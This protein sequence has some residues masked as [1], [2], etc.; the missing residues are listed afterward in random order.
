MSLDYSSSLEFDLFSDLENQSEEE[1]TE[2]IREPTMEEYMTITRINY[3]SGNEKGRIELKG[4]FLI[5]LRDNA[6]SG[7]NAASKRKIETNEVNIKVDWDPT[8]IEFESWLASKFR[9]HK[10][11]DRYTKNALWDYWRRGDDEE[12]ITDNGLSNPR[13]DNLIEEN[14]IAQIFR[15]DTDIFRLFICDGNSIRYEDYEWYDTIDDG[16]LKEEALINKWI[17]EES[18]KV[19]EESSDDKWDHDSPV[20]E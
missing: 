16:E 1:V 7:I 12:V 17:L 6:F 9:N 15:I 10:T 3:E 19:M 11:M 14:E 18:M 4:R 13:D 8:N 2:A 20:D 5:E